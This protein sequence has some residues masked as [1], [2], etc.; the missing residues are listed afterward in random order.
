CSRGAGELR[1]AHSDA[2]A[3]AESPPPPAHPYYELFAA[4]ARIRCRAK[5]INEMKM[6]IAPK[7]QTIA[8]PEGKSHQKERNNPAIPPKSAMNQPMSKRFAVR[9]ARLIP[10]TAG[11]IK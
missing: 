3:V 4:L 11:T 6:R 5:P 7:V 2:A 10:Q 1:R 8:A 9:R